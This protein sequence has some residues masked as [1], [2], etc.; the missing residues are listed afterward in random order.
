[1]AR[2]ALIDDSAF[3]RLRLKQYF[4]NQAHEFLEAD[5]AEKG[6]ELISRE[7]PDIIFLD[8]LMPGIGGMGALK[9]LKGENNQIPVIV[10]T[11]DVQKGVKQE[12][13]SLGAVD[14]LNKP[15][16]RKELLSLVDKIL[17]NKGE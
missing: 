16:D 9:A 11:S 4:T 15:P 14:V 10:I 6:L 1:M 7:A 17:S 12:C 8:L 3:A 2:L 13:I 5:C